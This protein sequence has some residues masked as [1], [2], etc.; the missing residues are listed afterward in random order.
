MKLYY[1]RGACSLVVRILLHEIGV[2]VEYEAVDLKTKKTETGSDF[3][4]VNSKGQVPTLVLDNGEVLTENAVIH[5]YLA[6]TYHATQLLPIIGDFARYRVLEW[7][8]FVT[9]ELH[10]GFSPLFNSEVSQELKEKIF[11]PILRKKLTYV[12]RRL[13]GHKYL[14]KDTFTIPDPYLF[15]MLV[16]ASHFKIAITDWPN[17]TRYFTEVKNRKSVSQALKE[18]GL[19]R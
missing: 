18:E 5:Q 7:T 4:K 3:L 10:K 1:S 17:L 2:A 16:W 8:N 14:F 19:L 13:E 11:I 9:T 12:D 15:V 6:D